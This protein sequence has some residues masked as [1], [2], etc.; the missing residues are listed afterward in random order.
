MIMK[1]HPYDNSHSCEMQKGDMV[2]SCGVSEK[3]DF[4]K[5]TFL[6]KQCYHTAEPNFSPILLSYSAVVC[7][8]KKC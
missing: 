6:F 3:G 8:D 5:G 7:S 2:F 4:E 1:P